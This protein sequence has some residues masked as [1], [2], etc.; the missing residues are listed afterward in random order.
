MNPTFP[1]SHPQ[2]STGNYTFVFHF[3]TS[4]SGGGAIIATNTYNLER[5]GCEVYE[6]P[7]LASMTA[8]GLCYLYEVVINNDATY[9]CD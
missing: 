9:T 3:A 1:Y 6:A 4:A 2:G 5:A 7:Y 8:Y